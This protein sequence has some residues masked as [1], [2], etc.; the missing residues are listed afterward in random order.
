VP[1]WLFGEPA[2]VNGIEPGGRTAGK[3]YFTI[4][5]DEARKAARALENHRECRSCSVK[6]APA[7]GIAAAM[8]CMSGLR[9][10]S[11]LRGGRHEFGGD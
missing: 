4:A 5:I 11:L 7:E 8:I 9:W 6:G 3:A 2:F 1:G 10:C